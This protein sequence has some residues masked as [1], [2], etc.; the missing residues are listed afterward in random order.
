MDNELAKNKVD[1]HAEFYKGYQDKKDML[2]SEMELWENLLIEAEEVETKKDSILPI[3][4]MKQIDR[5][6]FYLI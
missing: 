5:I 1:N 4:L 2:N 3:S 6:H